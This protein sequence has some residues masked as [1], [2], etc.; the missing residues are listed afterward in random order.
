MLNTHDFFPTFFFGLSKD[1]SAFNFWTTQTLQRAL[2]CCL[3]EASGKICPWLACFGSVHADLPLEKHQSS[4]MAGAINGVNR[5]DPHGIEDD[6]VDK[7]SLMWCFSRS[8]LLQIV[9]FEV[10]FWELLF[11]TG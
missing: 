5:I 7:L 6:L 3:V 1:C 8:F 4:G 2:A 10:S 9:G 11:C